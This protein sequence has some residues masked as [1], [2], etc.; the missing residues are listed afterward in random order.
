LIG[1]RS[2]T[3]GYNYLLNLIRAI[4]AYAGD[5]LNPV[6]FLGPD[7]AEDDLAPFNYI[8]TVDLVRSAAFG[9][10]SRRLHALQGA[11]WGVDTAA[12]DC[13]KAQNIDVVF[14]AASFY[15]W[16]FPLPAIAWLSDFQHRHFPELFGFKAYW[17]RELGFRAQV[18]SGR[19]VMLSSE[20]ARK[21]CER[22]YPSSTGRTKVVRFAV[23]VDPASISANP[24][25]VARQYDLPDRF[26]YLPNQFW[27]HKDHRVVIEALRIL[28][29]QNC[30][31][32]VAASGEPHDSRHPGH[33]ETLRSLV[34]SYGLTDNFRF[35]GLIPRPHV[36]AL[37]RAC[38]A[39]INPSLF[40]GWSTTVE[41][42]KAFG[43]PM[44][45]SDLRVHREQ[46][47]S[48]ARFFAPESAEQLAELMFL[49]RQEMHDTTRFD[50]ERIVVEASQR[51][52][53][54]F[55]EN[56]TDVVERAVT[57]FKRI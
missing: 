53:R 56:F 1:G 48:T 11:L 20:D 6:L 21:D 36:T 35:L 37:L 10:G 19:L 8:A 15:G 12:I 28:K 41:E 7:V 57:S 5:R 14:E 32:V 44:L 47:T 49:Q 3:G 17:K 43:V 52:V 39:L 46:A 40:E 2:W 31:A 51:R 27:K 22:F 25:D 33:Y 26:F 34:N 45:L 16:R 9:V 38:A 55:A 24:A 30:D 18:A 4:D 29:E 23:P 54:Q 13:F 50:V 42:A